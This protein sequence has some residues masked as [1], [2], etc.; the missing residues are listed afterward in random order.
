MLFVIRY[1]YIFCISII[2]YLLFVIRISLICFSFSYCCLSPVN[3]FVASL[4]SFRIPYLLV[5]VRAHT[6]IYSFFSFA[7]SDLQEKDIEEVYIYVLIHCMLFKYDI[8]GYV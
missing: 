6:C 8:I 7:V 4:V 5:Y 1:P 3:F 2:G